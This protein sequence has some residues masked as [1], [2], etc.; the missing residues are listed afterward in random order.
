[1]TSETAQR[2]GCLGIIVD[3]LRKI[4][5]LSPKAP[6]A[7]PY[8][9][10]DDF[11]TPAELS[12]YKVL[13]SAL[14]PEVTLLA[15]VKLTDIL[16]V[17]RPNENMRYFN[18]IAQ[19]HV[20]FL[21]CNSSDMQP[22]L[23]IELDD[24]SHDRPSQKKKDAFKDEALRA[25]EVP[26]L[27]VK[28]L[29]Q[30]SRQA[31]LTQLRPFLVEPPADAPPTP[32]GS[33]PADQPIESDVLESSPPLCPK[34]GVPMVVRT[35]TQGRYKGRSFYGCVNYPKCREMLPIPSSLGTS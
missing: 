24:A 6:T 7:L 19:G 3:R 16:F 32:S 30:Y 12:Y 31:V 21:L 26:I 1:M 14:G 4:L 17:S 25:A 5:G 9:R 13:T 28:P 10:R 27:R 23:V 18:K 11:L 35:A 22:V 2:P 34:C 8:R 20:D 15:K 29:K 33:L